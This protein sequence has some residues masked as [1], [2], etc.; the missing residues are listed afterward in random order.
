MIEDQKKFLGDGTSARNQLTR[1]LHFSNLLC[2]FA[3][4]ADNHQTFLHI[5]FYQNSQSTQRKNK[6]IPLNENSDRP[7]FRNDEITKGLRPS[8]C[9]FF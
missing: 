2:L 6:I 9:Q 4:S 1:G 8:C 3:S 7:L 5:F